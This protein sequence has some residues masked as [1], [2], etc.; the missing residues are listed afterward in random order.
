MFIF[1]E[2]CSSASAGN[3]EP[4]SGSLTPSPSW[5]DREENRKEKAKLVGWD[6]NRVTQ[7]Q[8]EKKAITVT[9]IKRTY[10]MQRS[11]HLMLCWLLSSKCPSFSQFPA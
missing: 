8:K 10:S 1:K 3:K 11:H 5:R 6:E 4:R 9:L 7:L 2:C